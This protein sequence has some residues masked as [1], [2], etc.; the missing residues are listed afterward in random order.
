MAQISYRGNLSSAKF[1]FSVR[2]SSRSV[3]VPTIDNYY[4][5]RI[6]PSGTMQ[7]PGIPQAIYLENVMPTPDGYKT[8]G[9]AVT[10]EAGLAYKYCNECYVN[11]AGVGVSRAILLSV[12]SD[13]TGYTHY[14]LYNGTAYSVVQPAAPYK[15]SLY[16]PSSV[17]A[18]VVNSVAY[19]YNSVSGGQQLYT[20]VISSGVCTLTNVYWSVTP[21]NFLSSTFIR[22]I[23]NSYN[24]LI[25]YDGTT[26]YWSS[27]SNPLDFVS[28]LVTG[29]GSIIPNNLYSEI[30]RC[31]PTVTGFNIY[32]TTEVV[33]AIYTGNARY[34]FKFKLIEDSRGLPITSTTLRSGVCGYIPETLSS[35]MNYSAHVYCGADS[36]IR[37]I[38]D[39][40]SGIVAQD[41]IDPLLSSSLIEDVTISTGYL[42]LVYSQDATVTAQSSHYYSTRVIPVREVLDRYICI[43]H[44]AYWSSETTS[45]DKH[46]VYTYLSVYDKL[47]KRWG[48]LK[49]PHRNV[50]QDINTVKLLYS[51]VSGAMTITELEFNSDISDSTNS[52]G[53]IIFGR[54]QYVRGKNLILQSSNFEMN[55]LDSD[56]SYVSP[57][58]QAIPSLNGKDFGTPKVLA[59]GVSNKDIYE[60]WCEVEGTNVSVSISGS[61]NL[62]TIGLIFNP[63]GTF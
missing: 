21:S 33:S 46:L 2:H 60:G 39:S 20:L 35:L 18:A 49:I 24:Y 47:I 37:I 52:T 7:S 27:L 38:S 9:R 54:F 5:K 29:A 19:L 56:G 55:N 58:V 41:F 6:D 16:D 48:R 42:S 25:A 3:I 45:H 23:L 62:V 53:K 12:Y 13:P 17:S 59:T 34:P 51:N 44:G 40:Q 4:D 30:V 1:P 61:F 15:L 43:S 11:I 31:V 14:V 63:G 22:G 10:T 8:V 28:S 26:I 32:T 36:Q 50:I 57:E